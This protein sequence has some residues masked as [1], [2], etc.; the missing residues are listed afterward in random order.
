MLTV[1]VCT[2]IGL[3]AMIVAGGWKRG[4]WNV[5][6]AQTDTIAVCKGWH[7]SIKPESVA[8]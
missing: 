3:P 2:S 7:P 1:K 8:E 6:H 4:F 5:S